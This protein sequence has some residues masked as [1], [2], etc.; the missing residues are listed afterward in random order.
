LGEEI[1]NVF[2]PEEK[3]MKSKKIRRAN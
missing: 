2:Q 1:E 3:K